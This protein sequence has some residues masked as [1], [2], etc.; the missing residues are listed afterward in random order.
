M[1]I[2]N[3]IGIGIISIFMITLVVAFIVEFGL[4]ALLFLLVFILLSWEMVNL[5]FS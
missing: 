5:V 2:K 4:V 1:K 3:K